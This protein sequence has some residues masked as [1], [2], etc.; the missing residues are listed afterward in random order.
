MKVSPLINRFTDELDLLVIVRTDYGA[1]L[2]RGNIHIHKGEVLA[3]RENQS[4]KLIN[5][6]ISIN[7]DPSFVSNRNMLLHFQTSSRFIDT[8]FHAKCLAFCY[9]HLDVEVSLV[10]HF[11]LILNFEK[12]QSV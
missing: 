3:F 1:E 12:A 8:S 5:S 7:A 6:L 10:L 2:H 9:T 11:F 4:L